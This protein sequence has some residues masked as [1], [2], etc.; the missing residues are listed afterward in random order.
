MAA[1]PPGGSGLLLDFSQSVRTVVAGLAGREVS[2]WEIADELLM[3]H[4]VYGRSQLR[5]FSPPRG[6]REPIER[7]LMLVASL[8]DRDAVRASPARE[9]DGRM[10]LLSLA[11][12]E[13]ELGLLYRRW[14][15]AARLADDVAVSRETVFRGWALPQRPSEWVELAVA[16]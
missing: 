11:R 2:A 13:P 8:F 15:I 16:P 10:T 14:G 5:R 12:L 7:W 4:P 1:P 3:V 9:I 6:R